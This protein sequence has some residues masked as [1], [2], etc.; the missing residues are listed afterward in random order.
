[1]AD[2][3]TVV[4]PTLDLQLFN[5]EGDQIDY[6][7]FD[8]LELSDVADSEEREFFVNGVGDIDPVTGNRKT[9]FDTNIRGKAIPSGQA[10]AGFILKF[11]YQS[12]KLKSE[13]ELQLKNNWMHGIF[14]EFHI[15]SKNQYGQW[16]LMELLGEV[17]DTI[18]NAAAAGP[19]RQSSQGNYQGVKTLNLYIP[20]PSLTSFSVKMFQ[21][22]LSDTAL[23]GDFLKCD[24]IGI[25]NRKG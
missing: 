6:T 23:N 22:A 1:M 21:Q 15:E 3:L 19:A 11:S 18:T 10:F 8:R 5:E 2:K 12:E 20:L 25:L 7:F 17:D 16:T 4:P 13:A 9:K 14:L 24:F